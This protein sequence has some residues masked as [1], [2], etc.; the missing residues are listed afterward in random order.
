MSDL[1]QRF[2]N[3]PILKPSDVKPSRPDLKV[4]CLLNPGAFVYQGKIGLLL[5]VAERPVPEAG[6]VSTPVLDPAAEGGLRVLRVRADDPKLKGDDPRA[7]E[8]DGRTYLTTLSHLRLAWS[9]DGEHFRVAERPTIMGRGGL[10]TY[11]VEDCRVTKLGEAY[12][13]TYTAVSECG[14]GV[15]MI[16]TTDWQ[17][18][19]PQG[20][21]FPPHNK[22]CAIFGRKVGGSYFAFHRPSGVGLGGN[23]L[24]L[25]DSPDLIHWGN[26][27]CLATTRPGM[28]DS[29]RLGAGAE[30]IET[31][32]GWLEIY[33]GA[34]EHHRYCLGG[35][36]LDLEDP[37]RVV[38]RS[39]EPIMTPKEPYE[40]T[41][42]FGKVV[43]TNGHVVEGD[44]IR[45]YYG[46]SDEVICGAT[47][48]V[49][50][51]LASLGKH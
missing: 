1:G 25:A 36:L 6:W 34:D 46:A 28:W 19:E 17:T 30:P 39:A 33:H 48:S 27:K 42:F 11:G 40:L 31:K 51:I 16:K 24:W 29:G 2:T 9:E 14:V 37:S 45:M 49:A 10:E 38:A 8:Y 50:E 47:L 18:F 20:M 5:R 32:Q 35:L 3:N 23:Y 43:F 12:Y 15:G 22:D 4:E 41:G 26:H 21:I 7:F 44:R 13:L